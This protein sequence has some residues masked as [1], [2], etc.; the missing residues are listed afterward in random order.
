MIWDTLPPYTAVKTAPFSATDNME[1]NMIPFCFINRATTLP[2]RVLGVTA[3]YALLAI[4]TGGTAHAQAYNFTSLD[5]PIFT[6]ATPVGINNSGEIVGNIEGFS[7]V[8]GFL[9]NPTTNSLTRFDDPLGLLGGTYAQGINNNGQIVGYYYDSS[10]DSHGFLYNSTTNTFTNFDDPLGDPILGGTTPNGIN[11]SGEIVGSYVN[12]SGDGNGF[13]YNSTNNTFTTF[14]GPVGTSGS[15]GGIN[16]NGEIVGYS[17]VSG[18]YVY[19]PT[20]NT[21]TTLD[22]PL[23]VNGSYPLGIND[24]GEVVG[25]YFDSSYSGHGY[26]FN[27][28]SNTFTTLDDPLGVPSAGVGTLPSGINDS[29]E[30]TGAYLDINSNSHGFVAT[31]NVAPEPTSLALLAMASIPLLGMI[32]CRKAVAGNT[33]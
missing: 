3:L 24:S 29:G 20:S 21:F 1:E 11:D 2:R 22:N 14:D 23:G 17:G 12:S 15:V 30:I 9:Y 4:A 33:I 26:L 28:T 19:N 31:L 10:F 7:R 32:R 13:L 16:N 25:Y 18:S 5:S 8:D 27:P 6:G